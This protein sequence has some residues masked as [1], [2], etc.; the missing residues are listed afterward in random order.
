M[1]AAK[2]P[3]RKDPAERR[4]LNGSAIWSQLIGRKEDRH[5]VYVNQGDPD[6]MAEYDSLGYEVEILTEGGVRPMGGRVC[7]LGE[8]IVMRGLVLMSIDKAEYARIEM[9][10]ADG[11]GGQ[12]HADRIEQSLITQQLGRDTQR[13]IKDPYLQWQ[14]GVSAPEPIITTVR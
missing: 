4:S 7:K 1:P 9:E 2:L 11:T 5:Y 12:L 3:P 8:P 10:G 13:G 6:A 14:S